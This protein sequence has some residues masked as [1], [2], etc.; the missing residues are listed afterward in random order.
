MDNIEHWSCVLDK[1]GVYPKVDAFIQEVLEVCRKHGLSIAHEDHQG[2]FII[3]DYTEV[4]SSRLL[5]ANVDL[6]SEKTVDKGL[7][8]QV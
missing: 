3:E 8:L 7:D 4:M 5:Y 2:G 1:D 6:Q